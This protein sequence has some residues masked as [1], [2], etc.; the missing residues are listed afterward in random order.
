VE[1]AALTCALCGNAVNDPGRAAAVRDKLVCGECRRVVSASEPVRVLPYAGRET[2]WRQWLWP[3][4]VTALLLLATLLMTAQRH[5]AVARARAQEMR[6]LA[7]EARA[8]AVAAAAAAT[9]QSRQAEARP[10]R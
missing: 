5:A 3:T 8:Q 1:N 4:A 10:S 7:A 9:V 2:R 6:A